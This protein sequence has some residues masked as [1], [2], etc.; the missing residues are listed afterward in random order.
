[1]D[2]F[3]VYTCY[4]YRTKNKL[5]KHQIV[6]NDYCYLEMPTKCN[7][8]L[9]HNHGEKSLIVPFIIYFDLESLLPKIHSCQNNPE[10]SYADRKA[11]HEP[12][13]CA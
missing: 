8:I 10:K 4:S 6:C 2:T 5:K 9:E 11:N 1:M 12:S 7:K 13:G 3:T